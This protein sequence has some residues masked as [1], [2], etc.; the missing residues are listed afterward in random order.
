MDVG[1]MR[2]GG[3]LGFYGNPS[4]ESAVTDAKG[5]ILVDQAEGAGS[6]GPPVAGRLSSAEAAV[7]KSA[8]QGET[9]ISH[10]SLDTTDGTLVAA[11][12][13]F[14]NQRRIIGALFV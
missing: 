12:P 6:A 13:I 10:L 11:A 1:G 8:L 3:R 4:S 2:S 5:V 9:D 14:D 7:L